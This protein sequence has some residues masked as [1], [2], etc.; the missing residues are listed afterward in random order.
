MPRRP[1]VALPADGLHTP[2]QAAHALGIP[3]H[4]ITRWAR[5]GKIAAAAQMPAPVPG[6]VQRFYTLAE[7]EPLVATYK[8]R[9]IRRAPDTR[10]PA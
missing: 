8:R 1:S 10:T 3:V 9:V 2:N 4:V 7:L 6:G 5:A